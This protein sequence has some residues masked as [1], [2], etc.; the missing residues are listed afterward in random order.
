MWQWREVMF[1]LFDTS[2]V[3]C[4]NV[5]NGT[6]VYLFIYLFFLIKSCDLDILC[7]GMEVCS[8]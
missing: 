5:S 8:L 3:F 1:T 4:S 2:I 7:N 6:L